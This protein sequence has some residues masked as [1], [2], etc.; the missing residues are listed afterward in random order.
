MYVRTSLGA[1]F[2]NKGAPRICRSLREVNTNK[3]NGPDFIPALILK[4]QADESPTHPPA[5]NNFQQEPETG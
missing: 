1:L 2:L 5:N 3:A 4:E